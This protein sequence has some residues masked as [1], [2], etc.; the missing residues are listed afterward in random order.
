MKGPVFL[1]GFMGTGKTKIGR[2]LALRLGRVF[3]DTDHL[4]EER[5]GLS[6]PQIFAT[7]GEAQFRQLEHQCLAEAAARPEV[8]IA[9]GGGAITQERNWELIGRTG[10]VVV[11]L[12]ASVDTILERVSRKEDR[13][14]LAGLSSL[15]KRVAIERLLAE[16]ASFYHRADIQFPTSDQVDPET[17]AARLAQTLE[18]WDADHRRGP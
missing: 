17:T 1:T 9:L 10:G 7:Q 2:L 4:I 6:I 5:A 18:Q 12:Q 8:V 16:R 3:V 13:P 14:L 15:E 11:C